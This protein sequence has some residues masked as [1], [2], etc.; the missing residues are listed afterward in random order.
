MINISS[1]R[2]YKKKIE[3]FQKVKNKYLDYNIV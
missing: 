1:I 3:L 2:L